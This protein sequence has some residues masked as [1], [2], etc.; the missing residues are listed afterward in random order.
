MLIAV[1]LP[2][3]VSA[4]VLC[5]LPIAM[6][7]NAFSHLLSAACI[8]SNVIFITVH[9]PWSFILGR[10]FEMYCRMKTQTN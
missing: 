4:Q 3:Q 7:T 1:V 2:C 9:L 8:C 10:E 5:P 6:S